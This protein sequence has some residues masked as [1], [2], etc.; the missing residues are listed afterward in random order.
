L[1]CRLSSR[2]RWATSCVD[3]LDPE[4]GYTVVFGVGGVFVV[5]IGTL[6]LGVVPVEIYARIA[7]AFFRGETLKPGSSVL[8]LGERHRPT[9]GL[10]DTREGT[11]IAP[12][13]SN[14]PPGRDDQVT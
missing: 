11:V 4:Y 8:L 7:P 2:S 12:D 3:Y 10:P 14:L 9:L 1:I 6:L 5:G 13:L